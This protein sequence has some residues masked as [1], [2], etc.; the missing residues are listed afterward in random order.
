LETGCDARPEGKV[1]RQMAQ[2]IGNAKALE[3]IALLQVVACIV[4]RRPVLD[5]IDIQLDLL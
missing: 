2:A 3:V 5:G 4:G 1:F